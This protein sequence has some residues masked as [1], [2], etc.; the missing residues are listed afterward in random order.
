MTHQIPTDNNPLPFSKKEQLPNIKALSSNGKKA[1]R[2]LKNYSIIAGGIGLITGP[3]EHQVSIAILLGKL[4]NDMGHLYG[5]SFSDNQSKI[6]VAAILGGVHTHWIN[7]YLLKLFRYTPVS[8]QSANIFL[9][10]AIT[11]S[12]VYYIGKLFLIHFE[13]GVWNHKT[14]K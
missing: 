7:R 1:K 5:L 10:P 12:I 2:L 8:I 6:L 13:S 3:V 9:R 4:L 11:S 14:Q